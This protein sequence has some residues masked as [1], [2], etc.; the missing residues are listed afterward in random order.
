MNIADVVSRALNDLNKAQAQT[1]SDYTATVTKVEGSTA[2]V[3]IEGSSIA[4]TPVAMTTACK[5]G[6]TVRVR[7][8][9]GRGW[10]T[11][12]DSAPPENNKEIKK[13]VGGKMDSDMNNRSKS[14][15][16]ADGLMRF[17][18]NTI[19]I[20]SENLKLDEKGNAKFSGD[21]EAAGGTFKGNLEAASGTFN[22]TLRGATYEDSTSK[23]TMDIGSYQASAGNVT[24][25]FKIGGYVNGNPSNDY[26]EVEITL[27]KVAGETLPKLYIAGTVKSSPSDP[28]G[29]GV[30]MGI[31]D[32]GVHFY[33]SWSST[34][35][36]SSLPWGY[37]P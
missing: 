26:L 6:D 14:I 21:L 37:N 33:G 3:Q 30:S 27:Y 16:I 1:G 15:T 7:V 31:D 5:K 35:V 24:P 20:D 23:F 13:E 22:G 18:A 28:N 11:G 36:H 2:Y 8:A 10:I 34:T 17:L 32:T 29:Y 12:N 9:N 4:D 19:V 25:A